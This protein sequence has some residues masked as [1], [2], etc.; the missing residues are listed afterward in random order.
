[1]DQKISPIKRKRVS[2]EIFRQLY[3]MIN[4]HAYKPGDQLPSERELAEQFAVSRASVREAVKTL[5]TMGLIES[6]V[7]S[8]GG[9]FVKEVT[10]ETMISPF[11]SFLGNKK[12]LLIE[13]MEY[14]LV[15]ETEI[16]RLAATRRTE[17]DL[18]KIENSI[19]EMRREVASGKLG[20]EGD[21]MFHESVAL[22]THNQVFAHM[23]EF[24]KTLLVKTRESSLSV[25]GIPE[26]GIKHHQSI[27]EAIKEGN[28][29]EAASRMRNHINE[30]MMNVHKHEGV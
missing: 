29:E 20:L 22:A 30:A 3:N 2:E 16:A 27:F 21:N 25:K 4:N 9:N 28:A 5:E 18:S 7:G 14:R 24:A 19:H 1:M 10:I 17:E 6:S 26:K 13:M 23:Q 12:N 8:G 15:L 11:A